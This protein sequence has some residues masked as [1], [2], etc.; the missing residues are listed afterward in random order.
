VRQADQP[1]SV[2]C[3][4]IQFVKFYLH[5]LT[6]MDSVW[7]S[8]FMLLHSYFLVCTLAR[9]VTNQIYDT[10]GSLTFRRNKQSRMINGA[11]TRKTSCTPTGDS[12]TQSKVNKASEW[13]GGGDRVCRHMP[14]L[15]ILGSNLV[16]SAPFRKRYATVNIILIINLLQTWTQF[17][18]QIDS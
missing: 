11:R 7:A 1:T 16:G 17:G 14:L 10:A 12:H 15:K 3:R 9:W 5:A 4:D 18:K 13:R 8:I 6:T 2:Q